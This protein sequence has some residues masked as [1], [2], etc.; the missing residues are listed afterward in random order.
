[1]AEN[2][3]KVLNEAILEETLGE[4]W[5]YFL[6][7]YDARSAEFKDRVKRDR[8]VHEMAEKL[9]QT[10]ILYYILSSLVEQCQGKAISVCAL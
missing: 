1:M 7:L 6:C 5:Q 3:S 9:E 10:S 8:A 4:L 2:A